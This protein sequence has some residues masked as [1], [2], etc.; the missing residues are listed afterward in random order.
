MKAANAS[1]AA[2][3]QDAQA[4][5]LSEPPVTQALSNERSEAAV[6]QREFKSDRAAPARE[7]QQPGSVV[8]EAVVEDSGSEAQTEHFLVLEQRVWEVRG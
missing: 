1:A 5:V 8:F 6:A 7:S 2:A 3:F 4:A